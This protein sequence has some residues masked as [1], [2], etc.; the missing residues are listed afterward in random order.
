MS[1]TEISIKKFSEELFDSLIF[2][3]VTISDSRMIKLIEDIKNLTLRDDQVIIRNWEFLNDKFGNKCTFLQ[4]TIRYLRI[5]KA[6]EIIF[7]EYVN[8]IVSNE[9]ININ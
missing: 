2:S 7:D 9:N 1:I 3:Y 8:I 6:E 4:N 5:C